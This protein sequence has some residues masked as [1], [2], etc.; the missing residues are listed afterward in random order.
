MSSS[1][2]GTYTVTVKVQDDDSIDSGEELSVEESFTVEI[3]PTN[4]FD[5]TYSDVS[6]ESTRES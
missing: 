6:L 5:G 4:C 3:L 1:D 2:V